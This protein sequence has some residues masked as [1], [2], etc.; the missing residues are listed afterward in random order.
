MQKEVTPLS[1][2]RLVVDVEIVK[3]S[4][5]LLIGVRRSTCLVRLCIKTHCKI[6]MGLLANPGVPGKLLLNTIYMHVCVCVCELQ[7]RRILV[8]D[9][10]MS[11]TA[12][13]FYPHNWMAF[14]RLNKRHVMLCYVISHIYKW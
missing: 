14:V 7:Q 10:Q 6:M 3:S 5:S 9:V 1:P 13:I 8:V 12:I 2:S 11:T 4:E